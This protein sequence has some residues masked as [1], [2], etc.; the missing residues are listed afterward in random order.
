MNFYFTEMW[1]VLEGSFHNSD[2]KTRVI[3][4]LGLGGTFL[5]SSTPK[6]PAHTIHQAATL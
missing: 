1:K 6:T 2:V 4:W 3:E 5:K